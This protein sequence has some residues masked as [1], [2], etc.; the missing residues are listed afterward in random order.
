MVVLPVP[1]GPTTSTRRCSPATART[2]AAWGSS[3]AA[4]RRLVPTLAAAQD[5]SRASWSSTAGALRRRSTTCSVTARPS[6]RQATP[7]FAAGCSSTHRPAAS[8]ESRSTTST[9]SAA[10]LATSAGRR[11]AIS[12]ARSAR[13]HVDGRRGHRHQRLGDDRFLLPVDRARQ[14]SLTIGEGQ[15]SEPGLVRSFRPLGTKPLGLDRL[16]LARPAVEHGIALQAVQGAGTGLRAV[17]VVDPGGHRLRQLRLH[18]GVALGEQ[19]QQPAGTP[20]M[21]AWP[22]LTSP[23][24]TPS[25]ADSSERRAAA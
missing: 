24:D 8:A 11:A 15:R 7:C 16:G 14:A 17:V 22:S 20:S 10:E 5:N 9:T 25:R 2:A 6:R 1:A 23:Q 12:R 3:P 21:S 18:L 13:S 19:L 4:T